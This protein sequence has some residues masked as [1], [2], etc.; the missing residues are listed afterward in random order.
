MSG[1][2]TKM[3]RARSRRS[4]DEEGATGRPIGAAAVGSGGRISVSVQMPGRRFFRGNVSARGVRAATMPEAAWCLQRQG[5]VLSSTQNSTLIANAPVS[6]DSPY[7]MTKSSSLLGLPGM[8]SRASGRCASA[9]SSSSDAWSAASAQMET[10]AR[11]AN[12][13]VNAFAHVV[14]CATLASSAGAVNRYSSSSSSL[15]FA[16]RDYA[17]SYV[18]S[19]VVTGGSILRVA[20]R[21]TLG[22]DYGSGELSRGHGPG[23]GSVDG[24][25]GLATVLHSDAIEGDGSGLVALVDNATLSLSGVRHTSTVVASLHRRRSFRR[26]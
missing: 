15:S 8:T 7:R 11:L 2:A 19:I 23:D 25:D 10:S 16:A 24:N 5:R 9:S 12:E 14:C 17:S 26:R 13:S 6:T 20:S 18:G 1:G 4:V 21:S 22:S 3:A